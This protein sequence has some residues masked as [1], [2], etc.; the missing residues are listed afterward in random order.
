MSVLRLYAATALTV[1]TVI[2]FRLMQHQ[3]RATVPAVAVSAHDSD[4]YPGMVTSPED[5]GVRVTAIEVAS[6][7][8]LSFVSATYSVQFAGKPRL[9]TGGSHEAAVEALRQAGVDDA[10]FSLTR[11]TPGAVLPPQ[12]PRT[13]FV[14]AMPLVRRLTLL[15]AELT[16]R[17][18]AGRRLTKTV[19]AL[20]KHRLNRAIHAEERRRVG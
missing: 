20:P 4:D 16:F 2:V 5:V 13:M 6:P 10:T 8:P 17:D 14:L 3:R 12:R 18:P 9:V 7:Y 15:E 1:L 11:F 19:S